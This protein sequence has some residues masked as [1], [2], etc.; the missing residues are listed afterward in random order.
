[1]EILGLDVKG[2]WREDGKIR[3]KRDRL[4]Q[5]RDQVRL[6]KRT[7]VYPFLDRISRVKNIWT[8]RT[9][10]AVWSA[11][12]AYILNKLLSRLNLVS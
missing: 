7:Q 5:K 9:Y 4:H 10:L 12:P 8:C 6:R 1:M 3:V 11:S 2:R